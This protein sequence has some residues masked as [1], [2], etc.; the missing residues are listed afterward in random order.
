MDYF[1]EDLEQLKKTSKVE[2][3]ANTCNFLLKSEF[4]KQMNPSELLIYP[5]EEQSYIRGMILESAGYYKNDKLVVRLASER[6]IS[7]IGVYENEFSIS[8]D[9]FSYVLMLNETKIGDLITTS[10]SNGYGTKQEDDVVRNYTIGKAISLPK[11]VN[12][13]FEVL[14]KLI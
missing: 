5:I 8:N 4:I 9:R 10:S 7:V 12:G 6:S 11:L 3:K 13:N 2:E 1:L 14:C